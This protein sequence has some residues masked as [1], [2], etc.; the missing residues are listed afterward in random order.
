MLS[1]IVVIGWLAIEFEIEIFDRIAESSNERD[2]L[3]IIRLTFSLLDVFA[4]GVTAFPKTTSQKHPGGWEHP[5]CHAQS[6]V[7]ST[8]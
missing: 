1:C 7:C 6:R 5:P 2:N 4:K 3:N 8:T